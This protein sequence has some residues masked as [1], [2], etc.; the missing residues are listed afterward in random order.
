MITYTKGLQASYI[1]PSLNI[2]LGKS[3]SPGLIVTLKKRA[4]SNNGG[5]VNSYK[6]EAIEPVTVGALKGTKD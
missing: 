6:E 4:L 1:L 2:S 5:V 3:N